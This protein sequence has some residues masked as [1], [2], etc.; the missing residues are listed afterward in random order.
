VG[1]GLASYLKKRWGIPT[2][3]VTAHV[4]DALK[5]EGVFAIVAK[6]FTN[7]IFLRAVTAAQDH[8][9]SRSS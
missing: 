2:I 5:S 6:P 7:D 8:L 1:I 4:Q 9:G 3:I